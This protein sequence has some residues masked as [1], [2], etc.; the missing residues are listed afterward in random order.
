MFLHAIFAERSLRVGCAFEL[1]LKTK[2][3]L[4]EE[5]T[6]LIGGRVGEFIGIDEGCRAL[7][8]FAKMLQMSE[9][10]TLRRVLPVVPFSSLQIDFRLTFFSE[11][12]VRAMQMFLTR[13]EL[14]LAVQ[15]ARSEV[16]AR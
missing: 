14:V 4:I 3:V 5:G 13:N 16:D 15:G 1:G 6:L 10:C 12:T 8:R 7:S 2:A 9:F 11:Y